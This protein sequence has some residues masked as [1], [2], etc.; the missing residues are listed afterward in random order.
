MLGQMI[1]LVEVKGFSLGLETISSYRA[2]I[3]HSVEGISSSRETNSMRVEWIS[4]S[5]EH[6]SHGV[7]GISSN[8]EGILG[9]REMNSRD[10]EANSRICLL[11][12][13]IIEFRSWRKHPVIKRG[14]FRT[15]GML[16]EKGWFSCL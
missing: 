6:I 15:C 10:R 7:E 13:D 14:W 12:I 11:I 9:G 4:R 5:V 3:S 16:S 8:P 1:I 2:R